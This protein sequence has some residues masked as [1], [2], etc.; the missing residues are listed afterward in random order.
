MN[1][2]R[3][4]GH[5]SCLVLINCHILIITSSHHHIITPSP[6]PPPSL[7]PSLSIDLMFTFTNPNFLLF[8]DVKD[9]KYV[10]NYDMPHSIEDYVHRIG[11]TGRANTTGTSL[12]FFTSDN[13]KLARELVEVLREAG[14][15]VEPALET[16]VSKSYT[17]G[18]LDGRKRWGNN[19]RGGYRGGR[20][21]SGGPRPVLTGAN[22]GWNGPRY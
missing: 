13:I 17:S 8:I 21:K 3:N 4:L 1:N 7:Y 9:V 18:G 20:F 5:H 2:N 6:P 10:I 12:T 14:Q 19:G 15:Q 16:M 11:R 22:L